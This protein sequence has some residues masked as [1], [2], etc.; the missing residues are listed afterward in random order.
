MFTFDRKTLDA[1]GAFLVGE[2]ERLDQTLHLPLHSVSWPR[3]IDLREDVT[4]A[5]ETSSFT[6]STFAAVGGTKPGGKNWVG[7]KTTNI[8]GMAVDIAKV[9]APL[10]LWALELGW[11]VVELEAAAKLGRPIDTQKYEGMKIKYNMDVDEMVYVGDEEVGATGLC[12]NPAV[13]AE[14]STL[15]WDT[16]TPR[17]I[18]DDVNDLINAAWERSAFAV[19]PD[20]LRLSPRK[21]ARLVQP[22]TDAGSMSLLKYIAEQC[23]SNI[24]NGRPLEIHP[25]KW[26]TDRGVAGKDRAVVYTRSMEYV[27]FPLVPLQKT[28]LEYRGLSQLTVY[29]GK[30]GHVEFVY[31]ETLCYMDGD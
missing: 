24:Q 21:F 28:P 16:A 22:V 6:V 7:A 26:L 8:P 11:S 2:L 14:N 29:F 18:L 5:D 3:D 27:R 19:V 15:D 20:Q 17:Q 13:H 25:L 4:I 12:N 10:H 9:P 30:L 23:I 31:P 1:A